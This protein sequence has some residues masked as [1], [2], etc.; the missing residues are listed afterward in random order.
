MIIL[1]KAEFIDSIPPE[2]KELD[3]WICWKLENRDGKATKIPINPRTGGNAM[4]NNKETWA[5]FET[6]LEACFQNKYSGLGFMFSNENDILGIDIDHCRNIE[7]GELSEQAKDILSTLDSYS[8]LSPSE[9]GI[10]ILC[11]GKLPDKGRRNGCIEMYETGRFFTVTGKVLTDYSRNIEERT[12]TLSLIHSKYIA[13]QQ[14]QQDVRT[15]TSVS[16]DADDIIRK[17][18]EAANGSKFQSLFS[19]NWQ[20]MYTSQSE[21]DLALCNLLAFWCGC[22]FNKMDEL[23][24]QSGLYREKWNKQHG[25]DTYGNMTLNEAIRNCRE[26]YDPKKNM[27]SVEAKIYRC[28]DAGNAE[29]FADMLKGEYLY[30]AEQSSWYRYNGKLWEPDVSNRIIQDAISCLRQAQKE[31]LDIP[32]EDRR[33]KTLKWLISSESQAKLSAALNLM[34]SVPFMTARIGQFDRNDMLLNVQNGTVNLRT[35]ELQ[36]HDKKDYFTKICNASYNP[37]AK[38]EVFDSFL[39]EILEENEDK[40]R[41]IQKLC[42]YCCT[43]KVTEQQFY[44]AKGSGKNGKTVLF[45]AIKYCLGNYGITASP[46]ILMVKDMGS[47]PNDIARLNG[48][49]FVLMSEPDPGKRFSDNAIK[50]LTGGDTLVARYLHK[51][52]FEFQMLGKMI[53]LTNHEIRVIGTDHGLYRRI[54]VIP[55]TY[56]VPDNKTD[57]SLSEKLIADS[58]AILA[59]MVKG[60]MMWQQEGLEQPQEL[61]ESKDEYLRG[62]D[63]VGLFIEERCSDEGKVKASDLYA[64]YKLWCSETGEYELSNR[65]FSKRLREKGYVTFKSNVIYW[66][67]LSLGVGRNREQKQINSYN[68]NSYRD[69][70][71][72][73]PSMSQVP[74]KEKEW[75]NEAEGFFDS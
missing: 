18:S 66:N 53:M 70:A 63:A 54:I 5:S 9:S 27:E 10:H 72:N 26:V 35:G 64:E 19:G 3:Q 48:A 56:Q 15:F 16:L 22:D 57:K 74:N 24:R 2:L 23:F 67:N 13:K 37:D 44:Q 33:Q 12:E 11:K 59:W 60:C 7:T 39:D 28:T 31:A 20:G 4:S 42:G 45:E 68:K 1:T 30:V 43:A 14:K 75:W 62:Q 32:D 61:I 55:F 36:P 29:R 52:F 71:K 25:A 38:S 21:A 41:Y 65:E 50:S 46:D 8:E 40:K 34:S 51:E 49:R 6:A 69:L 58:E 73:S 47:I 17:A